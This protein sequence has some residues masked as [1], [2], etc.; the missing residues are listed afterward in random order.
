MDSRPI[1]ASRFKEVNPL[2]GRLWTDMHRLAREVY[3]EFNLGS[4]IR[5]DLRTDESGKL[6]ILEANPKPD[7]KSLSAGV[8]SLVSAGLA[9]TTLSYVD[10]I[11]SLF[12]HR[13]DLLL[14]H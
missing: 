4:L 12:A 11:L 2:E 14:R 3:L 7:L 8:T 9:Q 6:Y 5:L 13:L 1:T 10:L